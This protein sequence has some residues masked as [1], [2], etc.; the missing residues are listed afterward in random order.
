MTRTLMTF[1]MMLLAVSVRG[2][3]WCGTGSASI[4][5]DG[6]S[7]CTWTMDVEAAGQLVVSARLLVQVSHPWVGD[8]R[9]T[10]A[11]PG[12]ALVTLLDRP[13]MPDD[14]GWIGPWGCGGDDLSVF[15]DDGGAMAA[16]DTC[17]QFDAP[18]IS[19]NKRPLEPLSGLYGAAVSGLWRVTVSDVSP[20]DAGTVS[21][22]CLT[23]VTSPDCNT[24]G[25]PDIDDIAGGDSQDDNGDGVPDECECTAD[26]NGDG[27]VGI[28]DLLDLIGQFGGSGSGDL[29]GDGDIDAN[30]L[31]NMLS[32]WGEC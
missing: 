29:D 23:L 3:T 26:L 7:V 19:G 21:N 24:N 1:A 10:L 32:Q 16:E 14:G 11:S 15:F 12:G 17:S 20:I 6:Q 22:I 2:D 8:L 31:L 13:G 18:V 9:V 27:L 5:D 30:D 4:P 25:V 28:D